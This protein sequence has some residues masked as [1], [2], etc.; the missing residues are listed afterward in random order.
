MNVVIIGAGLVGT[1]LG[2]TLR[3]N[4]HDI[5]IIERNAPRCALIADTM[6]VLAIHGSGSNPK[7]L[8]R[9]GIANADMVIAATPVDEVNL[10]CCSIAKQYNVEHRIARIRT[11]I[12]SGGHVRPD[13]FG[14][15]QVIYP[16]QSTQDAVLN[17][18]ETPGAI[19]V[20]DFQQHAVLMRSFLLKEGMPIVDRDLR[21]LNADPAGRL[22]LV[23]AIIR[24]DEVIIPRGES[25]LRPGDKL[26]CIFP[27]SARRDVLGLMGIDSNAK[28]R[29]IVFGD[30][31]TAI[32]IASA[33]ESEV[34]RVTF[35]DPDAKHAD[36]AAAHLR[37]SD[38]L[39]GDAN[40]ID[41][42]I[43]ANVRYTDFFIAATEQNDRNILSCLLAKSEGAKE[44]VAVLTDEKHLD[45]FQSIGINHVV[46]PRQLTAAGILNAVLPG[47][48]GTSLH[49]Q[50][51][52]IDVLRLPVRDRTAIAH[53]PLKDSWKRV[54]GTSIV[55]AI[56][57]DG[58]M[59]V[60]RGDTVLLPGDLVLVFARSA[61]VRRLRKMF[62]LE[63]LTS[64]G[65]HA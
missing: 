42:L 5:A 19:D 9:A 29:V 1:S 48:V 56:L 55:G 23:V 45:L 47:F 8:E 36:V 20:Q 35:I 65:I 43:E 63:N 28:R 22:L 10:V 24:G 50:K 53:R 32:N 57:R 62:G 12:F 11:D 40:D 16:E 37:S 13:H 17:I 34:E 26:L 39:H 61:G 60:P 52:D 27:N 6:D 21:E 25:I 30:T 7:D 2:E 46:N 44:V 59:L 31:L 14:I 64:G 3:A 58:E 54:V 33:L 38:V 41:V 49:I 15:T 51:S 18:V 4:G